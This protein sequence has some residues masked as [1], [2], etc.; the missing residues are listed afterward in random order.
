VLVLLL[1]HVGAPPP[2]VRQRKLYI[3]ADQLKA[4][5]DWLQA[6]GY[7]F[8]TL[9]KAVASDE[10]PVACLTFDDGFRELVT[11][12]LPVLKDLPATVFPVTSQ[13]GQRGVLFDGI[14]ADL[15]SCDE[16]RTLE[17]AGWE[18]GSHAHEH[19]RKPTLENL[20]A[21]QRALLEN[22]GAKATA[23]AYPYGAY[24]AETIAAAQRAGFRCAATTRSGQA[25]RATPF[26]LR[27]VI[28]S[29]FGAVTAFE[30]LKL[31]GV[32][33]GVYPLRP[34]PV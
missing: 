5:V 9:T 18:I 27:R 30:R 10:E 23:L 17:Q 14:P 25:D 7:R 28:L 12:V 11:D 4:H 3:T 8:T 13:V 33:H 20:E 21:S 2:N 22:L 15:A 29:G 1:H 31:L 24:D 32:H 19:V 34:R 26:Q 6:K 16:L